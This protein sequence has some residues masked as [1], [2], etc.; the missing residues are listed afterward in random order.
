MQTLTSHPR[1]IVS[2]DAELQCKPSAPPAPQSCLESAMSPKVTVVIPAYNAEKFI[3]EA[4][5]SVFAQTLSDIEIIVVDDGSTDGTNRILETFSDE[6][7]TVLRQENRGVSAARNAGLAVTRAPYIFFLDADDILLPNA[8]YRMARILDDNPQHVAC[9]AH[10]VRITEAGSELSTRSYL[11]WKMFPTG[12]TLR[13]LAAKNFISGA[14]CVRTDAARSVRGFDATLKLGEDWE[15]WCRLAVLGDFAAM[16]NDI[17]LLYRQRFGSAN[18]RWRRSPLQ[19]NFEALDIIYSNPTIRQRFSPAELRRKRRLAEI[20]A[21]WTGARNE[22][23]QGRML[24]FL[25]YMAVGAL[26]Y[27]DSILRPR[28]VYLFVRGLQ[29]QIGR[30]AAETARELHLAQ[31]DEHS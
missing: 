19:P 7:L 2:T 25:A 17:V 20:D 16:P 3:R 6:R 30:P 18:F 22:Y 26:R 27:P 21:F 8:L 4:I 23:V 12:N 5:E 10:H 15:F 31:L 28:L 13:H 11:R 24:K 9:F 29:Q 14:I 1:P